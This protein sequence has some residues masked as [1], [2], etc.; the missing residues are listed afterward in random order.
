MDQLLSSEILI[1]IF[2]FLDCPIAFSKTCRRFS[3]ITREASPVASFLINRHTRQNALFEAIKLGKP[4]CTGEVIQ[5]LMNKNVTA[6]KYLLLTLYSC[7]T[8]G[9]HGTTEILPV[10]WGSQK[11]LSA[12][13]FAALLSTATKLYGDEVFDHNGLNVVS[14]FNAWYAF[15]RVLVV[16]YD[17]AV[18]FTD[19]RMIGGSE[20]FM[21]QH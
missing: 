12:S 2:E 20:F 17:I 21:T 10:K 6:S 7:Y 11:S 15:L 1:H 9:S 8:T 16:K 5:S 18:E 14:G 19:M 4:L 3:S 13:T